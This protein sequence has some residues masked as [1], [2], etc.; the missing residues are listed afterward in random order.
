MIKIIFNIV[1]QISEYFFNNNNDY[2]IV[3]DRLKNKDEEIISADELRNRF[4]FYKST[5][6]LASK[7]KIFYYRLFND[8]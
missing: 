2:Q 7:N 5:F 4:G 3:L 1:Y 6:D 8:K